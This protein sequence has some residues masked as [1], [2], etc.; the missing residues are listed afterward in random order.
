MVILVVGLKPHRKAWTLSARPGESVLNYVLFNGCPAVVV[1]VKPGAPLIA[2]DCLTL[3][4][5]CEIDLP[6]PPQDDDRNDEKD[7]RSASGKYE[8]ICDVVFE[9]LDLCV[10][11]ARVIIQVD[12]QLEKSA[13]EEAHLQVPVTSNQ[14]E[15]AGIAT[16]SSD[17]DAAREAVKGAVHLLVAAAIRSKS[18]KEA[19]KEID[20]DRG[21]IA[22]WRIP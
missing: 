16:S 9:Y 11:W 17:V 20:R 22:M 5:L 10:D 14:D 15:A 12:G 4:Q 19:R 6:P 18:S 8:G 21:G 1:P 7:L 3:E 13:P 2:W